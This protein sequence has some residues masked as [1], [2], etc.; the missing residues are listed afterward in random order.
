MNHVKFVF[1]T[2]FLLGVLCTS[3][4]IMYS[5][6]EKIVWSCGAN[7][8]NRSYQVFQLNRPAAYFD[9]IVYDE[10]VFDDAKYV[11]TVQI[12]VDYVGERTLTGTGR[13]SAGTTIRVRAF[14][15]TVA[16]NVDDDEFDS[17]YGRCIRN[18]ELN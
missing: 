3:N 4:S 11:E 12:T 16:F 5:G 14:A 2:L 10:P 1:T 8:A 13:T 7:I 18:V 6:K 17:A 9:L 15:G